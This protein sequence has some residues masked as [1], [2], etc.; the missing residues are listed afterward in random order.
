MMFGK[1]KIILQDWSLKELR[2]TNNLVN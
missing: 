2:D 1:E